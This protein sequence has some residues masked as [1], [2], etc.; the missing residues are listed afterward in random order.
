[1]NRKFTKLFFATLLLS[2]STGGY[3]QNTVKIKSILKSTKTQQLNSLAEETG[4]NY[5][6]NLDKALEIAKEKNLPING[7]DEK[8]NY[9]E[10]VGVYENSDLL[11]YYKFNNNVA[12]GSKASSLTTLKAQYL[13]E[14]GYLGQGITVGIWD[15][16][17][18]A[19]NKGF[20]NRLVTKN[21]YNQ[22]V[23]GPDK[24][25]HATHVAGTMVA[26]DKVA[27]GKSK[28]FLP[29]GK[30]HSYDWTSDA[31]EMINEAKKGLL[32]SNHSYGAYAPAVLEIFT[33]RFFGT[34][35][36][37]SSVI[38]L[39][40]SLAPHYTPVYAAGNDRDDFRNYNP[41]GNGMNLLTGAALSK[42]VI[43]VAAV[44]GIENYS[45]PADVKA[46][47]FSSYGPPNDFRIKPDIAAKGVNVMSLDYRDK[48]GESQLPSSG[49][50]MAA[51]AVSGALG[52]LHQYYDAHFDKFMFSS[53]LKGLV[54]H[55]ASEAGPTPGP[56]FMFG[57]GLLNIEAASKVIEDAYEEVAVIAEEK[58]K[59]GKRFEKKFK[60]DGL[61]PLSATIAWTD[62]PAVG[63]A[64][65]NFETEYNKKT[66]INDLDL[67]I[68]NLD[69]NKEYFPWV[70]D[71]T[72]PTT[73]PISIQADNS[74]DNIEKIDID[75]APAG[76]YKLI[77][78]HKGQLKEL[79]EET[80]TRNGRETTEYN[81]VDTDSTNFSLI[82]TGL[83]SKLSDID[84]VTASSFSFYP[85]PASE[86]LYLA[87][88]S[89]IQK[90]TIF[91][92]IYDIAGRRVKTN[93]SL[94][95]AKSG[96]NVSALQGG[97]YIIKFH[98]K[99]IKG[100][101]KFIKK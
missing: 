75:D 38:D 64:P 33:P 87:D 65:A 59:Q 51:P 54:S 68:I 98:D 76:N 91:F 93:I 23:H 21:T 34:Y 41:S 42:N 71:K 16:A 1:M 69:T 61:E 19:D 4:L 24:V 101:Y 14:K 63:V 56:D 49:T 3:S 92:D 97:V 8:G 73:G 26:N 77:V 94:L 22:A 88:D 78:S 10:L 5:Q 31:N 80:V 85:N 15:G 20:D 45:S 55:T 11:K 17:P 47:S 79:K 83:N 52:L 7:F 82:V 12:I 58:L 2:L 100:S 90:E 40:T 95:E 30:I 37:S 62:V 70:L 46:A 48:T 72:M 43:V 6:Q 32:V 60:Y 89:F 35:T 66:L 39:I 28:G 84:N 9:F 27:N 86:I 13:H 96:I 99:K 36:Q 29:K 74:V 53:T 81:A 67:R 25:F 18:A 44:E 50:S 57:W